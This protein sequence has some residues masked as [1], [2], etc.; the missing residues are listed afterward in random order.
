LAKTRS[1]TV[2]IDAPPAEV[3]AVLCDV[4]RWPEWQRNVSRATGTIQVGSQ[5]IVANVLPSSGRTIITRRRVVAVQPG[6]DVRMRSAVGA[7]ARLTL[8]PIDSGTR[9]EVTQSTTAPGY[10]AWLGWLAAAARGKN[11]AKYLQTRLE[12]SNQALKRHTEQT[13]KHR[14]EDDPGTT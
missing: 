4:G 5:V 8:S 3:W 11:W 14:A 10:L 13:L 1:A 12:N 6:A 9:T 2:T 7:E